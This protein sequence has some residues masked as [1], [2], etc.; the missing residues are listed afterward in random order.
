VDDGEEEEENPLK[1]EEGL[2]LEEK[3]EKFMSSAL[4][5]NYAGDESPNP[6]DVEEEDDRDYAIAHFADAWAF[7]TK[8]HAYKWL[9]GK[10]SAVLL[11][12]SQDSISE[13]IGKD[14]IRGLN[15]EKGHWKYNDVCQAQFYIADWRLSNFLEEQYPGEEHL[16]GSVITITG[17]GINA[18][19]LT[20]AGYMRQVWPTTGLEMLA[21]LQRA[22]NAGDGK[23]Y[24]CKITPKSDYR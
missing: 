22:V 7:L 3:M 2:T 15:A 10:V 23:S 9:L 16:L 19:A 18:Q 6:S 20:C 14:I 5:P 1:A 11:T 4:N 17:S 21:A 13:Q 8:S 24:E 12:D